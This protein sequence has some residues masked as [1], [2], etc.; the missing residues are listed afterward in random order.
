VAAQVQRGRAGGIVKGS[1]DGRLTMEFVS[2]ETTVKAGDVVI[3]SGLGGVYPKGLVIGEV[4]EV[5]RD[6]SAL[7]QS[8]AL[9]PGGD[10]AGLEEVL[11]LIGEPAPVETSGGE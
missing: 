3:T 8:I 5:E 9:E 2:Q 10:L 1:L 11:V 6:T 7:Y 4:T